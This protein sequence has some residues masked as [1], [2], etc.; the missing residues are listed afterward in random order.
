MPLLARERPRC[1]GSFYLEALLTSEA[2]RE[3]KVVEQRADCDD[4]RVVSNALQLSEP[5]RE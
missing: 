4:F 3:P 2:V 5:D 1:V